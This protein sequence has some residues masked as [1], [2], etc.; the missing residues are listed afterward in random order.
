[1]VFVWSCPP[2]WL[3]VAVP[4]L[5]HEFTHFVWWTR[6]FVDQHAVLKAAHSDS[7]D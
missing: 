7:A 4:L 3:N 5:L 6:A 1:M 2:L